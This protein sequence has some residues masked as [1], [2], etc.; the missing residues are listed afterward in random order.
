MFSG[1]DVVEGAALW[2]GVLEVTRIKVHPT[3]VEQEAAVS[4]DF[5]PLARGGFDE[6]VSATVEDPAAD[7]VRKFSWAKSARSRVLGLCAKEGAFHA[8]N[9]ERVMGGQPVTQLCVVPGHRFA[10]SDSYGL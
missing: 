9:L 5:T 4:G 1:D 3:A 6:A 10:L 7:L 8:V 2:G